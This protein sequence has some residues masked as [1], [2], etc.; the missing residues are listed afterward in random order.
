LPSVWAVFETTAWLS[1][2]PIQLAD[3]VPAIRISS[4]QALIE[5]AQ[6]GMLEPKALAQQERAEIFFGDSADMRSDHL[7]FFP[8]KSILRIRLMKVTMFIA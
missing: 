4:G 7:R 6:E 5:Q 8:P 3:I 2:L 1:T